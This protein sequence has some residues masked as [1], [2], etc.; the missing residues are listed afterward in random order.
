MSLTGFLVKGFP[1]LTSQFVKNIVARL[2]TALANE[3]QQ[4]IRHPCKDKVLISQ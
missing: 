1:H 2:S 3:I 4:P